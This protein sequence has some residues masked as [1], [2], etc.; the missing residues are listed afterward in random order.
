MQRQA[1]LLVRGMVAAANCDGK[2]DDDERKGMLA[3]LE[4]AGASQAEREG[5]EFEM[6]NP[7]PVEALAKQADTP[8]LA[9]QFYAVSLLSMKID[10]DAEKA[11][12]RNLPLL[13]NMAPQQVLN[14]QQK[15]GIEVPT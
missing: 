8:E 9:E 13:L 11:Y 15:L 14:I 6:K 1:L 3:R 12:A 7:Q 4:K 5:L 10:T 2:I